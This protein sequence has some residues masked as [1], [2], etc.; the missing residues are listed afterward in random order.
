MTVEF[1]YEC[2][3]TGLIG[4]RVLLPAVKACKSGCGNVLEVSHWCKENMLDTVQ[5]LL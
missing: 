1:C 2:G 4:C 3:A 5:S